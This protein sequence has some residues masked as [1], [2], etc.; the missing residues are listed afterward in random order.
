M[1]EQQDSIYTDRS[2]REAIRD[3]IAQEERL[4]HEKEVAERER[5]EWSGNG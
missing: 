3:H 2:V 1:V 4:A 5:K